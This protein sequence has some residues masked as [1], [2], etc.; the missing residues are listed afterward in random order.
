MLLTIPA[1]AGEVI[2][3]LTILDIKLARIADPVKRAN[4][5]R[6]HASLAAAWAAAVPEPGALGHLVA[7][8]RQV[9]ETLWEVED[10]LREHERQ[11]DFGAAFVELAR[12]VYRTNDR[13]AALK[14][15]INA[16]L[17]STLIEEKSYAAY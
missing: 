4:V 7:D 14:R 17:G 2:D 1:S 5:A 13:R 8:L 16:R 12:S 3:K 10:A 9:N 15:E 11:G 6:E